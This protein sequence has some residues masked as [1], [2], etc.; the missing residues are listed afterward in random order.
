MRS[1]TSGR[2]PAA[3]SNSIASLAVGELDN[4]NVKD[5]IVA[6]VFNGKGKGLMMDAS[7]EGSKHTKL[8]K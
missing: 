5:P 6:F 1:P 3:I 8:D 7:L 4:S 2:I